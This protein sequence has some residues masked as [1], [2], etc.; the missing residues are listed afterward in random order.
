A[1]ET[2]DARGGFIHIDP[3][4]RQ[5]TSGRAL[6][7][8]D[9]EPGLEFLKR[10]PDRFRGGA[11][12]LGPASNFGG[13]FPAAEVELISLHGECK[14]ATVWFGE[15]AGPEA[16]RATVLP[17]GETIAGDPLEFVAEITAPQ[18]FVY[19]PDPAAVRAG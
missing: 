4:R 11:I 5:Q 16:W 18:A 7:I 12:K 15:L 6:R 13:K 8:E 14:E 1:I 10:L 3:D 9:Y 17:A 2:L 19:D